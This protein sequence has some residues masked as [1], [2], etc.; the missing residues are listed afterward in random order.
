MVY[1]KSKEDKSKEL[2]TTVVVKSSDVTKSISE[3]AK[4]NYTR[5]I[6]VII[7]IQ[8]LY[9]QAIS[10]LQS[11]YIKS[12][13]NIIEASFLAQQYLLFTNLFNWSNTPLTSLY[14]QQSDALTNNI[15]R[16]RDIN[17][18]LIINALEAAGSILKTCSDVVKAGAEGF[19]QKERQ[20]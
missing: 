8:P 19:I 11:E 13:K 3:I 20:P 6:D 1:S 14:I 16:G 5:L 12:I 15:I 18:Q 4:E 7:R 2:D 17:T 10:N 9:N